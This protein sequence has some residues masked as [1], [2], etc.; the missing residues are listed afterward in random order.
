MII[1]DFFVFFD[2]FL[3]ICLVFI[4]R[5]VREYEIEVIRWEFVSGKGWIYM[6]VFWVVIFDYYIWFIDSVSFIVD[7]FI[8]KVDIMVWCWVFFFNKVLC[9]C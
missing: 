9:F 4:I 5:W 1:N 2:V 8:V 6:D 3:F 7:F